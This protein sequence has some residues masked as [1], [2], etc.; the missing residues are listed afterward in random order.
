MQI[1][2]ALLENKTSL[3]ESLVFEMRA[4]TGF[5]QS[6]VNKMIDVHR[7]REGASLNDLKTS[8]QRNRNDL[9]SYFP[10]AAM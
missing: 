8:S 4:M 2:C 1:S 10:G 6:T 9:R 7:S 5:D 3:V